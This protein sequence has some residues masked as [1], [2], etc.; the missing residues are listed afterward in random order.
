[1]FSGISG[2]AVDFGLPEEF[3]SMSIQ[4]EHRLRLL[5]LIGRGEK[6]AVAYYCR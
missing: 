3:S 1:M 4:A 6:D 5:H 2:V